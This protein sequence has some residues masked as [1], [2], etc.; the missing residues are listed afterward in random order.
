MMR[1]FLALC[2]ALLVG[3]AVPAASAP[4]KGSSLRTSIFAGGCFWSAEHDMEGVRGVVDVVVG[5]SG[6]AKRNPTYENHEGHL[7]AI[8][9][10]WD[11]AR[12]TYPDLVAAFFRNIDPTDPNGQICDIGPSYRTAVFVETD[13]EKRVAE[14]VKADVA[15]QIRRP[16]AT[17][18][19]PRFTFWVGEGYH[20]DYAV[21]NPGHYKRYR[22]GCGRDARIRA[23][24]AGRG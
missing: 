15:R 18:I 5:Y 16:V 10:T 6:G 21:K 14:Q 1:V 11:P 24:W 19:L 13:A 20:Q 9:V 23:V 2:L 7:E 8:R 12:T 3:A 22:V 4:P 17:R